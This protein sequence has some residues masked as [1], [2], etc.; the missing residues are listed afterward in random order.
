MARNDKRSVRTIGALSALAAAALASPIALE[1]ARGH[2]G[3]A[4]QPSPAME[5]EQP[6]DTRIKV[7]AAKKKAI[8]AERR[9]RKSTVKKKANT[10]Q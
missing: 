6:A 3:P 5:R 4:V 2:T 8:I 7:A 9:P 10:P 1:P